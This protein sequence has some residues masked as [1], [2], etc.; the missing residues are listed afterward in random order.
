MVVVRYAALAALVVWLAGMLTIVFG[1][2][3]G[4]PLVSLACG[5]VVLL[6]L[7]VIKFV[8]PP[9]RAFIPR[10]ALVGLMIVVAALAFGEA[11]ATR[12]AVLVN[13]ALAAI[14]LFWYAHE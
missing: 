4:R 2:A 8:G 12:T 13:L 7:V 10:A 11:L 5:A 9:P 6:S 1:G 3:L 14:L